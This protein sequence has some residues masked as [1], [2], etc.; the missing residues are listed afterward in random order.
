MSDWYYFGC[1]Q[2]PGH[3]LFGEGMRPASGLSQRIKRIMES[4]F[5]G[6][7]PP[8]NE[9]ARLYEATISMLPG[10]GF[11]ALAWW[12]QSEDRRSGSN[13]V[14]F[15]PISPERVLPAFDDMI[16]EGQKRFPR[17]FRR[18]PQSLVRWN[19]NKSGEF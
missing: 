15:A 12:D 1:N 8:L 9:K 5:D 16:A 3:Y 4:R 13:S 7:L 10:I 18:L 19:P 14:L 17:V 6:T 2:G 11:M